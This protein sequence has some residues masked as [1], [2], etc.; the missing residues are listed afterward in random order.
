[1][2]DQPRGGFFTGP[3][4]NF[5]QFWIVGWTVWVEFATTTKNGNNFEI[6]VVNLIYSCKVAEYSK[7]FLF[8]VEICW[9]RLFIQMGDSVAQG[10]P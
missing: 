7:G 8:W 3:I 9:A 5:Y 10:G 2:G 6:S 1:V 4:Y